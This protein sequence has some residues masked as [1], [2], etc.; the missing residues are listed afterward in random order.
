M[1]IA[2]VPWAS[3]NAIFWFGSTRLTIEYGWLPHFRLTLVQ[4]TYLVGDV[5]AVIINDKAKCEAFGYLGAFFHCI[6]I[7]PLIVG[8]VIHG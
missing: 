3:S 5:C 8:L 6:I 4:P 7:A 2:L 1:R